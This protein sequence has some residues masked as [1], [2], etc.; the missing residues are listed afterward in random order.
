M[1]LA[2]AACAGVAACAKPVSR[3]DPQAPSAARPATHPTRWR[4]LA[5]DEIG[6][7][8]VHAVADDL[9]TLSARGSLPKDFDPLAFCTVLVDG[10]GEDA[11]TLAVGTC[12][13]P[14]S[15]TR[16]WVGLQS[17]HLAAMEVRPGPSVGLPVEDVLVI[18]LP[19]GQAG[20][21]AAWEGTATAVHELFH[22]FQASRAASV[23]F[24]MR[25]WSGGPSAPPSSPGLGSRGYLESEYPLLPGRF[26]LLMA[27][28]R[29]LLDADAVLRS[30]KTAADPAFQRA[31][32]AFVAARNK[33][34]KLGGVSIG[35]E[36]GWEFMEGT[37]VNASR[38]AL[39][40]LGHPDT[41]IVAQLASDR[42]LAGDATRR[43]YFY[44]HGGLQAAI[45]DEAAGAEAWTSKAF[46][47]QTRA[48]LPLF[49]IFQ[50][51]LQS[52]GDGVR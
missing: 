6:T 35:D 23:P 28:T 42:S 2:L 38:R 7:N 21:R 17:T 12:G 5:T 36:E 49:E 25:E 9:V 34:W 33:R 18:P 48:G 50:S 31:A 8:V 41:T 32:K 15:P 24:E 27:E 29:A 13:G 52:R 30:G 47:G 44:V 51:V 4:Y 1:A 22:R 10:W 40:T 39:R 11:T 14:P 19:R 20:T 3:Q 46:P 43:S 45:L 26:D 37:A 16:R